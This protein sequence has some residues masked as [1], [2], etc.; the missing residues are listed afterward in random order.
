[1]RK[2]IYKDSGKRIIKDYNRIEAKEG[3]WF[4]EKTLKCCRY[5]GKIYNYKALQRLT[6]GP[7]V[8]Q[9][10]FPSWESFFNIIF[11]NSFAKAAEME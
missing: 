4:C 7:V 6:G 8:S 5:G 2:P 9:N 1:M 3:N 10:Q 11:Y